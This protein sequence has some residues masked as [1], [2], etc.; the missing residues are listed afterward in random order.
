MTICTAKL[1]NL[2]E[3][4]TYLHE[5]PCIYAQGNTN[6]G[7]DQEKNTSKSNKERTDTSDLH[8]SS[9]SINTSMGE[10]AKSENRAA[11]SGD[12]VEI[13]NVLEKERAQIGQRIAKTGAL[14]KELGLES[15]K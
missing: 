2:P 10:I 11:S 8:D 12:V 4:S 9:K 5:K 15:R 1:A 3:T 6:T 14:M 7:S 13:K